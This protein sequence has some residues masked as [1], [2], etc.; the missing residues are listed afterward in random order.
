MPGKDEQVATTEALVW[1]NFRRDTKLVLFDF[2]TW[3]L[4]LILSINPYRLG[5]RTIADDIPH[6]NPHPLSAIK[7]GVEP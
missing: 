2:I 5:K 1:I 4:V 7:V 6:L 3:S